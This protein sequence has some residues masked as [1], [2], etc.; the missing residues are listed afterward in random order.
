MLLI[1]QFPKMTDLPKC[2]GSG[3]LLSRSQ[4]QND[5]LTCAAY[6][7]ISH[8]KADRSNR[9]A[10]ESKKKVEEKAKRGAD[11]RAKSNLGWFYVYQAIKYFVPE[12]ARGK[13]V[14]CPILLGK[15]K[16]GPMRRY[17]SGSF[18]VGRSTKPKSTA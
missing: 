16:Q 3:S 15:T 18:S 1:S 7:P 2:P 13:V 9:R 8:H 4:G 17:V 12:S 14:Y 5:C 11:E 6:V 10:Q